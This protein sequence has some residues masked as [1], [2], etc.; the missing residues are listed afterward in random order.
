[1]SALWGE[2]DRIRYARRIFSLTSAPQWTVGIGDDAAV[3]RRRSDLYEVFTHDLLLEDIHFATDRCDFRQLGWKALA[4][5]LSDI[6]AMAAHPVGAVLGLAIP[7]QA[8]PSHWQALLRGVQSCAKTFACPIVGGDTNASRRGWVISLAVLGQSRRK[9]V[10]RSGAKTGDS[11]WVTGT[12]GAAALGWALNKKKVDLNAA[13]PFLRRHA[14]PWPRLEWA[15]A[16]ASTGMVTAMIDLSDGLSGD[17]PH[18]AHASNVGF[19]VELDRLPQ[20]ASF[21]NL[22][23]RFRLDEKKLLLSG[24]EDYELLLTV[25]HTKRRAWEEF[26]RTAGIPVTCIG[27]ATQDRC[28]AYFEHA[29]SVQFDLKGF[30]HF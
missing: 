30:R 16:F 1:M 18:L 24:G 8:E 5:N 29:R 11:L 28:I 7:R 3:L 25:R 6:A 12:L 23:R 19:R 27:Q 9:P 13:K 10:L 15:Q 22:C 26:V 4:V 20:A 17:L 14:R 21:S 2:F